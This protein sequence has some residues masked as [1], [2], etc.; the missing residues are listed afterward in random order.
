[1]N[2]TIRDRKLKTCKL[3]CMQVMGSGG[4]EGTEGITFH[5]QMTELLLLSHI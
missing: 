1:M 3:V 5:H 4:S 2:R